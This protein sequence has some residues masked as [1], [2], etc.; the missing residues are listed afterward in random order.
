[1]KAQDNGKARASSIARRRNWN[2]RRTYYYL[3]LGRSL[4]QFATTVPTGT[5]TLPA[6]L[7]KTPSEDL[8]RIVENGQRSRTREDVIR[9]ANAA[10]IGAQRLNPLNTDHSANLARLSRSWAFVNALG[11]NDAPSNALLRQLVVTRPKDVD[12]NR[13]NQSLIYYKQATSLSPQNAQLWNEMAQVQFILGDTEG[14]LQ[15]LAHSEQVDSIFTQTYLLRGDLL[16]STGDRSGALA[17]YRRAAEASPTDVAI[18]SAIG[19]LSAQLG[20]G[21]GAAAAFKRM[22]EIQSA[23]LE[24]TQQQLAAHE[25]LVARSGGY[26][27]LL[28]A[29]TS[30]RDALQG[31]IASQKSQLHL[32]YRN[33]SLVLRDANRLTESLD[34]ARIAFSLANDSE[35]PTIE[36][37]IA[38]I[39]KRANP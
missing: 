4:L 25:R 17:A 37:L 5:V 12:L 19:V 33:L 2:R 29:A 32:S 13:L 24:A 18:H 11:P 26:S 28:P 21:G 8:L 7:S 16:S 20:D 30:R 1:M 36:A 39:Q 23:G 27:M 9:A 14:A 31:S 22:I 6:D 10:L 3:F 35:R 38:D 15:T 34:A